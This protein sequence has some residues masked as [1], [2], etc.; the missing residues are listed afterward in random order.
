MVGDGTLGRVCRGFAA[1]WLMASGCG[2]DGLEGTSTGSSSDG[3]TMTTSGQPVTTGTDTTDAPTT[4]TPTTGEPPTTTTVDP[5]TGEPPSTTTEMTTDPSTGVAPS[6]GDGQVDG[7]EEC[8]DGAANADDA[9]CTLG[10]KTAVCGDALVLQGVEGCDDGNVDAGDGCDE[11]CQLESCGDGKVQGM[12]ECDDGNAADD[13]ACLNTCT[14]AVCGDT[15]VFT[16]MEACDDGNDV[17]TDACLATCVAAECGD[18]QVWEGME[19]CDDGN[20]SDADMC[21]TGCK[22]PTCMDMLQDGAETDADCG[23]GVCP[24]CGLG[25]KCVVG[26]DC[27]SGLCTANVCVPPQ[28]CKQILAADPA[29]KSGKYNIDLDGVGPVP[30]FDVFCDMTN[31]GGGWTVF[32]AASGADGEQAMISDTEVVVNNPLMFQAYNVN[33]ARKVALSAIATET[34]FVRANNVW[35]RADKPAFDANLVVPNTTAKKAVTLM[36]SNNVMAAAFMGYANFNTTGGGD[37]GVSLSPDG[38]TSCNG[39]TTQ[40]FDH[41]LATYRMLNCNCDRQYLY[42]YSNGPADGDAGYDVH[43]ALG[44]WAATNAC[45][46]GEGGALA[47]YAAMR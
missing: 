1:A 31:S 33:R 14:N 3:G 17:E 29:A 19:E 18:A 24:K 8:D 32:Y 10:C 36:S 16:G 4:V 47:F 34:L 37:F 45:H 40:G 42:S 30:A 5:T 35:M 26:G 15:V 22:T 38:L 46:A 41:H 28:S 2:D 6:C 23:G 21:T 13:D 27:G 39:M 25:K 12:E 44:A 11:A 7:G 9:A 20:E 43:N